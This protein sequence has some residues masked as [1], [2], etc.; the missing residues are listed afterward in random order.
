MHTTLPKD[1]KIMVNFL[2][3]V[4]EN[5]TAKLPR[6]SLVAVLFYSPNQM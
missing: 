1:I 6:R 3:A 4:N 5:F 2:N